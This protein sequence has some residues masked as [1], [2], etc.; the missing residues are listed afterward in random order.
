[1][2][3]CPTTVIVRIYCF[4]DLYCH[5]YIA[6]L[7]L[8]EVYLVF[9]KSLHPCNQ[10][11]I[12]Q[13]CLHPILPRGEAPAAPPYIFPPHFPPPSCVANPSKFD[14]GQIKCKAAPMAHSARQSNRVKPRSDWPPPRLWGHYWHLSCA[15]G[16]R[17]FVRF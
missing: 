7:R 3:I 11:G 17:K 1:M 14:E 8:E 2:I 4:N 5:Q 12:P 9:V 10:L 13:I 16:T 15:L 6:T